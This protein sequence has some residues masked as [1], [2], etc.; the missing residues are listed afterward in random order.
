MPISST[1]VVWRS[2]STADSA[3][4][5]TTASG[6]VVW[7]AWC[8]SATTTNSASTGNQVWYAWNERYVYEVDGNSVSYQ[9]KPAPETEEQKQTRLQAEERRRLEAEERERVTREARERAERLLVDSLSPAQ[10]QQL[11]EMDA[12]IVQLETR[13]YKIRRGQKV[14][15]LNEQGREVALH[16][17]HPSDY[18][19][20]VADV[21]LAQKL[22]LETD[23]SAFLR[24]ANRTPVV[25]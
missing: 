2:W 14:V 3:T 16:C 7:V 13:R 22:M 21:M 24:I 20:P 4:T 25:Q 8:G 12:F 1:N 6:G 19:I 15:E 10:L 23:E 11:K 5:S 17:I 18:Q 9:Y